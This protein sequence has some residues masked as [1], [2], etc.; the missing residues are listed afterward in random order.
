MSRT[1]RKRGRW[2]AAL[3]VVVAA[4]AALQASDGGQE[5][6]ESRWY[7]G[8]GIGRSHILPAT[9]GTGYAVTD[10]HDTGYRL[11]IGY[12]WSERLSIEGHYARLGTARLT[13]GG[14]VDYADYGLAA[15]YFFYQG[16]PERPH[17]GLGLFARAGLG[18]MKNSANI[19]YQRSNDS[20]L[21]L[22]GGVE[23]GFGGGWAARLDLDLYD[24]DARLIAIGLVKRFGGDTRNES[25]P[26]SDGDGIDDRLDR[27]LATPSGAVVDHYGCELDGDSDGVVDRL[28]RC[29]ATPAGAE[30]GADGCTPDGDGDGVADPI[31]RC[32]ATPAG[33]EVNA[34]G[35]EPDSDG[36]G[37][38]DPTD[39]CP[40]TPA[41]AEVN[42]DGCEPDGDGDGVVDRL[43]R[44]PAS[45][46]GSEV[47]VAGCA[48][49]ASMVLKGVTF[50]TD[51]IELIGSSRQV[52]NKVADTLMRHPGVQVE[53]AGY[54]DNRGSREYNERLSR[55]RAEE[56]RDY[57]IERGVDPDRLRARGYGPADPIAD[58]ATEAGRAANRRV[59]LHVLD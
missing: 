48:V 37:V 57:L 22:G 32:P 30:V 52:L 29:P 39:R 59:E 1:E 10:R 53:V 47:D 5:A 31:D 19:P 50:A 28:D 54:T 2:L 17:H 41:G 20:Q 58:N 44:C 12:D 33:A 27:C 43:D 11:A 56:V 7:L 38:A 36:D 16:E 3:L 9:G 40:A 55:R 6:F 42:A 26:D 14:E 18:R 45:L 25:R 23:Y 49:L 24:Q 35:C 21:M 13:F 8:A 46:P 4:P 51:S 15:L 34:D